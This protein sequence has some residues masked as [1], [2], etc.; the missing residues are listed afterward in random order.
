VG[1]YLLP[2]WMTTQ[3]WLNFYGNCVTET[4]WRCNSNYVAEVVVPERRSSQ[5]LQEHVWQWLNVTY[6]K[7]RMT[8]MDFSYGGVRLCN[9][10]HDYLTSCGMTSSICDNGRCQHDQAGSRECSAANCRLPW[11]GRR[12]LLTRITTTSRHW[13][14]NLIVCT[15]WRWRVTWKLRFFPVSRGEVRLS[16]LGTS[17]TIWHIVL[18]P[19]DRWVWRNRWNENWQWKP[20]YSEDTYPNAISSTTN[21]TWPDL[22]SNLGRRCGK[23]KVGY[24]GDIWCRDCFSH[25]RSKLMKIIIVY[26]N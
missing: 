3:R 8:P 18:A 13:F 11:N 17:G 14:D 5:P 6:T 21:P 1:P 16:P 25:S 12:P 24:S 4:A 26:D 9:P 15:I 23:T 20:K 22:G 7:R 10:S 19:D 2:D